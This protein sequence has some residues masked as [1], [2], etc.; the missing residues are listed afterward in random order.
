[1]VS[2]DCVLTDPRSAV[3]SDPTPFEVDGTGSDRATRVP[4]DDDESADKVADE[5]SS[6]QVAKAREAGFL[7]ESGNAPRRW[8]YRQPPASEAGVSVVPS[9]V[10]EPGTVRGPGSVAASSSLEPSDDTVG[11]GP[12]SGDRRI[13]QAEDG[14]AVDDDGNV[15]MVPPSYNPSWA[16]RG[17][18]LADS[19][20]VTRVV[21]DHGATAVA[22]VDEEEPPA[23]GRAV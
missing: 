12:S 16:S 21:S 3:T 11:A 18:N 8:T 19:G 14:G 5:L 1:M 15:V 4:S 23:L 7:G 10:L 9:S 22:E 20:A 13:Q 17:A 6:A 2:L